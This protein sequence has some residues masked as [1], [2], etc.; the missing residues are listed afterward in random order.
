[1]SIKNI[2][3]GYPIFINQLKMKSFL[4]TL[5]STPQILENKFP[6]MKAKLDSMCGN[7]Q[8]SGNSATDQEA[9]FASL[10]EQ[11]NLH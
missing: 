1:M 8:G 10:L 2:G 4:N 5:K 7:G 3:V 9:A 6:Q 11:H